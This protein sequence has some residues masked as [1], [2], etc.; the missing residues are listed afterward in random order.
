ML[1]K[2]F[3]SLAALLF[4]L[5][6]LA[7]AIIYWAS[8]FNPDESVQEKL[9]LTQAKDL[10]Y[11][12]NALP[13][14][15]GKILAVVSSIREFGNTGRPTGYE[16]TELARAYWVFTANGFEVDIASPDGGEPY[17]LID[18]EDMGQYDFA[19]LN[20]QS[21]QKKI[22]S[23]FKL[24]DVRA[25]N[26]IAIYFVGGKGAMFDFPDNPTIQDLVKSFA[27]H[28]KIIAAVCHGPAALVNVK[29]N[30][31]WFVANK[32]VS[33]FTNNEELLLLSNAESIFP[34]LLQQKL[35]ERGA[36]FI[37]GPDYLEQ[38]S[39][40][41]GLVTGQNPWSVW[42]LAEET[43]RQLGYEP[44]PR[45]LT[46]EEQSVTLLQDFQ[47]NGLDYAEKTIGNNREVYKG[48]LVLMHAFVAAMKGELLNAGKLMILAESV[49]PLE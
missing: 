25:D 1:K 48:H 2:L 3:I 17:A 42:R 18:D 12:K 33:S 8:L 27:E 31:Q 35:E 39:V 23:T 43:V 26:Y 19:F 45:T 36:Q 41:N 34:F 7:T 24:T 16:L 37:A 21:V 22:K 5:L 40:S 11:L 15:R 30:D 9:K 29:I 6:I 4:L 47:T 38:I 14:T 28:K 49:R 20:D 13:P 46:D 44:L 32:K 10:D